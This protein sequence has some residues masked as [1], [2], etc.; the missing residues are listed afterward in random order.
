MRG[1][2]QWLTPSPRGGRRKSS[3]NMS[4]CKQR[5][6]KGIESIY[7]YIII[8]Y[9]YIFYTL[10][11]KDTVITNI[12]WPRVTFNIQV[13]CGSN[14]KNQSRGMPKGEAPRRV[15]AQG[16]LMGWNPSR[17]SSWWMTRFSHQNRV[18]GKLPAKETMNHLKMQLFLFNMK[19]LHWECQFPKDLMYTYSPKNC[20][21][22]SNLECPSPSL[23]TS[24]GEVVGSFRTFNKNRFSSNAIVHLHFMRMKMCRKCLFQIQVI[25][26]Y[27]YSCIYS[28][29][30][31]VRKQKYMIIIYYDIY[32]YI[33]FYVRTPLRFRKL[34]K[35]N[36]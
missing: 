28:I 21:Q 6:Q 12:A 22:T 4:L 24:L 20:P 16:S 19:P 13:V 33:V 25:D 35:E 31:Y 29:Q 18:Y 8:K 15:S 7:I 26:I 2:P 14:V 32:I 36:I 3:R 9:I 23:K 17:L 5:Y 10:Y 30:T 34:I 27:I 1:L 11:T